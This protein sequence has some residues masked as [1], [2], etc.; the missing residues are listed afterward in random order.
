MSDF[1]SDPAVQLNPQASSNVNAENPQT[2]SIS[3]GTKRDSE[4]QPRSSLRQTSRAWDHFTRRTINGE[5]KAVCN[6][7][8]KGFAGQQSS[9]TS[10]LLNHI[11]RCPKRIQESAPALASSPSQASKVYKKKDAETSTISAFDST[12]FDKALARQKIARMIIMHEL[13][14]RFVEYEGFRDLMSFVQPLL[15][16]ICRNT[17]KREVFKLFELKRLRQWLCWRILL[18]KFPLLRIC[19]HLAIKKRD[20]WS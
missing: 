7:C 5:M 2:H 16:K 10:H 15:G 19:G 12:A 9:G 3:G 6:H 20:I 14:L 17:V 11:D 4:G 18:V 1:D 8:G 13:P